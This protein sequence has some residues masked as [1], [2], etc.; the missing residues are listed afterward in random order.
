MKISIYG[1]ETSESNIQYEKA[2]T[3]SMINKDIQKQEEKKFQKEL[4]ELETTN[5]ERADEIKKAIRKKEIRDRNIYYFLTFLVCGF[6]VEY[7]SITYLP[8][9]S[10]IDSIIY[11]LIDSIVLVIAFTFAIVFNLFNKSGFSKILFWSTFILT[12]SSVFG[13]FLAG[14]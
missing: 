3:I 9:D 8:T 11:L 4:R 2:N 7:Q 6:Y 10:I 13:K 1:D 12:L 14:Y 5:P